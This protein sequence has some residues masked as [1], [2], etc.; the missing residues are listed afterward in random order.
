[1]NEAAQFPKTVSEIET[2]G[3]PEYV[4]L[5]IDEALV[6]DMKAMNPKSD[7]GLFRE[8]I[9]RA[10]YNAL[11]HG[12]SLNMACNAARVPP[13]LARKWLKQG[14]E[15]F[16]NLTDEDFE[17]IDDID[18]VLSPKARF[19]LEVNRIKGDMVIELQSGLQE[20][21]LEGGKEWI[22]TYILERTEPE[23]YNLKRKFQAD[24]DADVKATNTV[25]FE[26]MDGFMA[27]P[28]EDREFISKEMEDLEE[29]YKEDSCNPDNIKRDSE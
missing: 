11:S 6:K 7:K 23:F 5:P 24:V 14:Q 4:S 9:L 2:E 1:M 16:E 12:V 25:Q 27:R 3:A 13:A 28:E 22:A 29:I 26:L 18:E 21:A 8:D 20:K 17:G 15:D 10:I 19:Y